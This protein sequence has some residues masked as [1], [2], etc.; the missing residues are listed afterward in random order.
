MDE[1]FEKLRADLKKYREAVQEL[2][3]EVD[4]LYADRDGL[5]FAVAKL[6]RELQNE[7]KTDSN[8]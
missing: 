1:E 3:E 4:K 8:I 6:R 7:R 2:Q 5:L